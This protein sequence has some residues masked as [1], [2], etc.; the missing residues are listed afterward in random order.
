MTRIS[1]SLFGRLYVEVD[2]RPMAG[3]ESRKAEE[4]FCYLLLTRSHHTC[5]ERLVEVL[6]PGAPANHGRTYL[7]K[8]L[9][10]LQR[11]F[12]TA[13]P[14]LF[15]VEP[16]WVYVNSAAELALDV[17]CF[18]CAFQQALSQSGPCV[19]EPVAQALRD[20]VELYR[21]SLLESW[22]QEWLLFERER[23]RLSYIIMLE[24]LMA[25]C[26]AR[27]DHEA[28]LDYALRVLRLDRAH[29]GT[30][31]MLMQFNLMAGRP[32]AAMQQYDRCVNILRRD[33]GVEPAPKTTALYQQIRAGQHP[34]GS[35]RPAAPGA[36]G[37][38][39][40][41]MDVVDLQTRLTALEAALNRAQAE[42]RALRARLS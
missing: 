42:V 13:G 8:A 25:Y 6:W 4:L 38:A 32:A 28:G 15:I 31:R 5:R 22:Y 29:E 33:L 21:G 19:S 34:N 1:V 35:A 39:P 3:F 41:A 23:L 14:H 11:A 20:A 24:K 37:H 9:W 2:G 16:E 7:R 12:A 36:N 10:Q 26:A 17:G 30:H 40:S 18:E 27:H